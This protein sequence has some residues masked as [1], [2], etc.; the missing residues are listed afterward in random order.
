MD[1]LSMIFTAVAIFGALLNS[2]QRIEGFYCWILSN[3]FFIIFNMHHEHHSVAILFMF[4][5]IIT[6]NGIYTWMKK[7]D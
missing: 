7:D 1:G 6:L 3:I 5:L 2:Y 4:Y